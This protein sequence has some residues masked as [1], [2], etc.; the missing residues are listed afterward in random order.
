M[1]HALVHALGFLPDPPD[2]RDFL[3]RGLVRPKAVKLPPSYRVRTVGP[4]LEQGSAPRCVAFAT[5]TVKM[6]DEWRER[7]AWYAF[8]EP[9]LYDLCKQRDGKPEEEG[10]HLR[11]ALKIVQKEGYVAHGTYVRARHRAGPTRRFTL[12]SYV[13][14]DSLEEI[15]EAVKLVGPVAFGIRV[16]D[17]IHRPVDGVLPEPT[18][19]PFGGHAMVVTGWDDARGALRVKNSWGYDWADKGFA[20][21]P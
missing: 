14:L 1:S 12:K 11:V 4:V 13:K 5:A 20:W 9:W 21:L 7:K 2:P 3:W 10:T 6:V 19:K 15:K 16:D 18:G 8:D 17:G